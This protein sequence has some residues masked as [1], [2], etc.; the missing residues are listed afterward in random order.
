MEKEQRRA[1]KEKRRNRRKKREREGRH[2]GSRGRAGRRTCSRSASRDSS[3]CDSP[4]RKHARGRSPGPATG[5]KPS[6][7]QRRGSSQGRRRG[8][9]RS[10]S[11]ADMYRRGRGNTRSTASA[12][13]Y[14]RSCSSS[15]D[16]KSGDSKHRQK[17]SKPAAL[18]KVG[19]RQAAPGPPAHLAPET[20]PVL[21][22]EK[23][24]KRQP[25]QLPHTRLAQ[26]GSVCAFYNTVRGCSKVRIALLV[27]VAHL[28]WWALLGLCSQQAAPRVCH[29]HSLETAGGSTHE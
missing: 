23:A 25:P 4:H 26:E 8:Y 10:R 20:T 6:R 3:S 7:E 2:P 27:Q 21:A 9:S 16:L 5:I 13:K 15:P 28:P 24:P 22:V 12:W 17:P 19:Q 11:P 1:K 18:G 29:I 14:S